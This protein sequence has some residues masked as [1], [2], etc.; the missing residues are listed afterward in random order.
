MR[1]P[2]TLPAIVTISLLTT[3]GLGQA[4]DRPNANPN[5]TPNPNAPPLPVPTIQPTMPAPVPNLPD[6]GQVAAVT[7]LVDEELPTLGP[8]RELANLP[9]AVILARRSGGQAVALYETAQ[10]GPAAQ[11]GPVAD[12]PPGLPSLVP[13]LLAWTRTRTPTS[14]SLTP[15]PTAPTLAPAPLMANSGRRGLMEWLAGRG[16][17]STTR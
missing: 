2:L 12:R 3:T 7:E 15:T 4:V 17:S 5:A 9:K 8:I 11:P 14:A 16:P 13:D 1:R 10:V 6:P